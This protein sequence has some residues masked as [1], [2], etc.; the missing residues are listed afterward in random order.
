MTN[1]ILLMVHHSKPKPCFLYDFEI[2][3]EVAFPMNGQV[4]SQNM[5]QYAHRGQAPNQQEFGKKRWIGLCGDG[6]LIGP[7]FFKRNVTG[8]A[9]FEMLN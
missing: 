2:G 7:F 6:S 8:P 3:D 5:R 9:Y 4:N 1:G